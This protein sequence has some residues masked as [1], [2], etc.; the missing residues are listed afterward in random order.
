M[1]PS[2]AVVVVTY[3]S[4]EH[5]VGCLESLT[6]QEVVVVDNDSTDGTPQVVRERFPWVR[7]VQQENRGLAAAWKR[8]IQEVGS[9]RYLLILNADTRVVGDAVGRLVEFG[10]AHPDAAVVGPQLVNPD[11]SLQ[12]SIRGFPTT[13]R[14]ATEYLLLRRIAPRFPPFSAASGTRID[15][16]EVREAEWV[17]GAALFVRGQAIEDV[18]LPDDSFFLFSEEVDWCYRFNQAGWKVMYYPSATVVHIGEA[19]HQGRMARELARGNLRYMAKHHGFRAAERSRWVMLIGA[20]FQALL[21]RGWKRR[22]LWETARWLGSGSVA[23]LL[24]RP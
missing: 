1:V 14:L 12:R 24:D 13:W 4:I 20:G 5:I 15:H 16:A 2:V 7:L 6:G 23:E 3:N 18:G 9:R 22:V 17:V 10:D 19:S 11:G 8:G 21:R